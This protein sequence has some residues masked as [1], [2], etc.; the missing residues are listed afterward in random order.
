M[1]TIQ[2]DGD[3]YTIRP[4]AGSKEGDIIE[5]LDANN[6]G[7]R[8][9][10]YL[11]LGEEYTFTWKDTAEPQAEAFFKKQDGQWLISVKGEHKA[12]DVVRVTSKKG[13]QEQQLGESVGDGLFR[14]VKNNHFRRNP[15]GDSPKWCVQVY[16]QH[17]PGDIV[18]VSKSDN[19]TQKQQLI[20]EVQQGVWT[21]KMI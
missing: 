6:V 19:T 5:I 2:Q 11:P 9:E 4:P 3:I 13:V 18:D 8:I 7:H 21:A 15:T 10:L 17:K 12:G 1:T 20:S 16:S 14:P